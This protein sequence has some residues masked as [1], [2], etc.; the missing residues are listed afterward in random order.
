MATV[1]SATRHDDPPIRDTD[2]DLY[3]V[4]NDAERQPLT[5][6]RSHN[7]SST[8][9]PSRTLSLVKLARHT[10]GIIFLLVTILLFTTSNFLASVSYQQRLYHTTDCFRIYLQITHIPNH[11]LSLTSILLFFPSFSSFLLSGGYGTSV[12]SF[13]E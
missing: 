1:S 11:I 12:V 3:D 10:L 8:S 9:N 13:D 5:R 4:W 7:S 6:S 2:S